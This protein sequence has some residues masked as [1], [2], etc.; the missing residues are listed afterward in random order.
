MSSRRF[1]PDILICRFCVVVKA[2][3]D[4][5]DAPR[6]RTVPG[7]RLWDARLLWRCSICCRRHG[8]AWQT[9]TE[10]SGCDRKGH[11][12]TA[13][14]RAGRLEHFGEGLN[15]SKFGFKMT[16]DMFAYPRRAP[17]QRLLRNEVPDDY[18]NSVAW[19][20]QDE[21]HTRRSDLYLLVQRD[22]ALVHFDLSMRYFASLDIRSFEK[23]LS[24]VLAQ[25][26]L[27]PVASLPD[28]DSASGVYVMVFDEYRQ[29]YVGQAYDIRR[30]VKDHWIRRKSFDRL[31]FGDKYASIFPVDEFRPLD[32]TQ[33][34]A[35]RSDSPFDL[36]SDLVAASDP[37]F[38][39][40]RIDGGRPD[41]SRISPLVTMARQRQLVDRSL[42]V[43]FSY[44]Q[45]AKD[46][47]RAD[48][49]EARSS[50]SGSVGQMLSELDMSIYEVS[51]ED[52]LF[53]WSR[54][55]S[56]ARAAVNGD[57]TF[58]EYEGFLTAIGE[59]VIWPET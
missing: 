10:L 48:I 32:N 22:A 53:F 56:I 4:D 16:R 15:R 9:A 2:S 58:L 8:S 52:T 34:F 25:A 45:Q 39:L 3:W 49:Q 23:A 26:D 14:T 44:Y 47:V 54:R 1:A 18:W 36:E 27:C 51:D 41:V 46:Q 21:E 59:T 43:P 30:R 7:A 31:L 17:H 20:Y 42:V 11:V 35:M 55:D 5:G 19:E 12:M 13:T 57:I 37:R 24:H 6:L 33:L 40:N 50:G 29:F 38:T 28:W